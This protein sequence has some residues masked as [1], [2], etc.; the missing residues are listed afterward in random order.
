MLGAKGCFR[1]LSYLIQL[2]THLDHGGIVGK[3]EIA[4]T[5]VI[6]THGTDVIARREDR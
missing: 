3:Y 5:D 6:Q 4:G 2:G 1:S